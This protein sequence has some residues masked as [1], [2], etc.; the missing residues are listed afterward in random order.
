MSRLPWSLGY[1]DFEQLHD[2]DISGGGLPA[3]AYEDRALKAGECAKGWI[4]FTSIPGARPD[5]I[6]YAPQEG[7]T[8]VRWGF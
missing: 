1:D 8:I 5:G 4:N 6:Q 2:I 3:P 7:A